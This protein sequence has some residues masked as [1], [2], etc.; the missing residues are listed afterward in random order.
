MVPDIQRKVT[1]VA[2]H[3]SESSNFVIQI[4][5]TDHETGTVDF[6]FLLV[7]IHFVQTTCLVAG[8]YIYLP[9]SI[10]FSSNF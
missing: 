8:K 1:V 7:F 2:F 6:G 3:I 5:R 10:I 9:L 4:A